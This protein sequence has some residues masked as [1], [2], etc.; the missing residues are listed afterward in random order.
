MNPWILVIVLGFALAVALIVV[1]FLA[2]DNRDKD[3]QNAHL[4]AEMRRREEQARQAEAAM[5]GA[6]RNMVCMCDADE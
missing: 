1:F 6:L 4:L 2:L 5:S 3:T